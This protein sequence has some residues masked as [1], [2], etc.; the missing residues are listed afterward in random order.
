MV[1]IITRMDF[2]VAPILSGVCLINRLNHKVDPKCRSNRVANKYPKS[3]VLNKVGMEPA[4]GYGRN[5][6]SDPGPCI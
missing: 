2:Q 5:S 6:D 4:F 1:K 3:L